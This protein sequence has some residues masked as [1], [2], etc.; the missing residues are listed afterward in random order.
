MIADDSVRQSAD[1]S[2]GFA[3]ACQLLGFADFLRGL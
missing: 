2:F 3:K 1:T